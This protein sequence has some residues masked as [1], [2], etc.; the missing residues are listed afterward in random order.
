M[1]EKRRGSITST[2]KRSFIKA[3]TWE[4]IAFVIT[5]IA[6][7]LV[8]GDIGLS[9]KFTLVLTAIKI[10]FLYAHERIW[11]KIR[12]GRIYEKNNSRV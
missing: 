10:I 6:V 12:W 1:V 3:F 11:K 8:Y 5:L 4:A 9:I 2:P 7:Y